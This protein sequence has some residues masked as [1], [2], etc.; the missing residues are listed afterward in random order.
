LPGTKQS[1]EDHSAED[2]GT[3]RPKQ[4]T[5]GAA[6]RE[7]EEHPFARVFRT[8]G[9]RRPL[10]VAW[11]WWRA[12]WRTAW[13]PALMVIL[14]TGLLGA[15]SMAALAGA[16]RTESAYG[17]Y[18]QSIRAS[19]LMVN[20]PSPDTSLIAKVEHLPGV[21]SSAAFVGLDANPVVRGHV[22]DSFLTDSVESSVDGAFYR[23]D[24]LTVLHGRLPRATSTNEIALTPGIA[25]LFGVGVGGTVHYQLDDAKTQKVLGAAAFRV[26]AVVEA[27][28]ALV[29]QFDEQ[30]GAFLSPAATARYWR[31]IAYSW[32]G[33]RLDRAS[34]GLASFQSS[35]TH[36]S[37]EVG[38]GYA[39]EVRRMGTVQRQ[40]QNAIR[41]Q[42]A[43]LAVFGGL[44][45]LALLVLVSQSLAQWL[46]RSAGSLRTL[47][48]LGLTRRDAAMTCV[49]GPALAVVAG[50]A[51]AVAGA[52]ALS[53]LAP[54][55]PVRQFDP[56]RGT[57]FD[58]TVLVGSALILGVALL[59]L[60]AWMAWHRARPRLDTGMPSPSALGQA[61]ADVGLPRV[62]A[63]GIRFALEPPAGGRKSA[64]R[65]NLVG[66]AVA[67]LAVVTAAVFGASLDGLVSHP[68]RYG[69]NWDVLIQNQAGY[70][71]FL[72]SANPA[73]FH[74]GDG[75]LDRLMASQ[76]GVSGWS[77][78][79]FTQLT[80]D[81]HT[82]PVPVLGLA[83]HRGSVEPPTVAGR[84]LNASEHY[85]LGTRPERVPDQIEL[86][87]TTMRQ[88]GKH[89]G[90]TVMVTA[91]RAMRR[92]TVVGIVTLPSIGVGLTDHVSLGTGAM[93]SEA[94]LLSVEGLHSL[95]TSTNEAI[96]ALPSTIAIDLAPGVRPGSVVRPI[97]K[98]D[99][100]APPGG[101]YQVPRVLGASIVNANQ[102]T[103][104]P[105]ALALGVAALVSLSAA[106]AAT[107]RRRRRDLA[108]LQALGLTRR[109]RRGIIAWQTR[110]LL[111][112]AVMVGLPLGLLAGRW[113]W[114]GF[115][116]S[117]GVVPV[118]VLP[119]TSLAVGLT[120][121]LVAGPLLTSLPR[122]FSREAGTAS[123]LRT[124]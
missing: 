4:S 28:P 112:V 7:H 72:T 3:C 30:D 93:L 47:R 16:R 122:F 42:A 13:R 95:N 124:E 8:I 70:G 121:L 110:T 18:L 6:S 120:L 106:V 46:D 117:L 10:T 108:V 87:A 114:A 57:Q 105:L 92:L 56:V 69:W 17:R 68:D 77:T 20:I 102:M 1:S 113:T 35:L 15:V 19:D 23:E 101:V 123:L 26:T 74:G 67:V 107:A 11:Y 59:S 65:A 55:E 36:L 33:I 89:V 60:L 53:P 73:S 88:L 32:V 83:T 96:S 45:A 80:I 111:A 5:Y 82:V 40:V 66:T 9:R 34:A 52:V 29:D 116:T 75:A 99:I 98:A 37:T 22:D 25:R 71:A 90:D 51:L 27:P 39:F 31:E 86:G 62:V 48:A 115:A 49:L 58:P 63:L 43:A 97:L 12:T 91:G 103:G 21:R 109:Q 104:Q 14:L 119:L 78:F 2:L 44:A 24:T 94:T 38:Q 85:R 79:G 76:H 100:G 50:V 118:T 41:P 64:V 84:T 81:G 54:L 61:A